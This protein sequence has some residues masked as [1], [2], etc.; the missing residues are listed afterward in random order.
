[1][2]SGLPVVMLAVAALAAAPL[3]TTSGRVAGITEAEVAVWCGI[4][5]AAPPV[6]ALRWHAPVALIAWRGA[7]SASTGTS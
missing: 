3:A 6:G 2:M 4:P 1:M 5:Y 7:R